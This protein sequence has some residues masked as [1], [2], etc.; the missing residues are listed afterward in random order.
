MEPLLAKSWDS[1]T[2][3]TPTLSWH[4]RQVMEAADRLLSLRGSSALGAAGLSGSLL[5]LLERIVRFAAWGHDLGK[6]SE[7]FQRMLRRQGDQS[8]RHEAVS[9]YLLSKGPLADFFASHLPDPKGRWM[10]GA[11][12]AGHH[13]KF[14]GDGRPINDP[15]GATGL[16]LDH[17]DLQAWLRMVPGGMKTACPHIQ[18]QG[19]RASL[20]SNWI[21]ECALALEDGEPALDDDDG[22]VLAIAKSFLLAADMAGSALPG[23]GKGSEWIT[24]ALSAR[25]TREERMTLLDKKLKGQPLRD[26][27]EAAADSDAPW[28]FIKAG[29]GTGK[30]CPDS[31]RA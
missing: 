28:T 14:D 6:C 15:N 17:E 8:F 3:P 5:P 12:L 18:R 30:T 25:A 27:Q 20:L 2:A 1:V 21:V 24:E 16:L 13:R 7:G 31:K 4:T 19:L 10:V 11:C 23:E 22:R 26:F 9:W 29:C